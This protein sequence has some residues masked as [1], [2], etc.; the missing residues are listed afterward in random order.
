MM[1]VV[2]AFGYFSSRQLSSSDKPKDILKAVS[3]VAILPSGETPEIG[4]V[5]SSSGEL[6][7]P[8]LRSITKNGD[9]LLIFYAAKKV[10]VFRPGENRLVDIAPLIIDPSI[11]QVEGTRIAVKSG[12]GREDSALALK[13]KLSENYKKAKVD[14][15]PP[16]KRQDYPKTIVIDL[17]EDKKYDFVTNIITEIGGSRGVLPIGEDKPSDVDILILTGQ[18]LQ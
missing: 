15:L 17:T 9:R 2:V 3:K 12:N 6:K 16:S 5:D 10:Y 7:D 11:T 8:Y 18:D 14:T 1:I 13:A 4:I